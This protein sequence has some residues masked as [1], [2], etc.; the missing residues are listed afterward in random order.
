[1]ATLEAPS[2]FVSFPFL[3]PPLALAHLLPP[4]LYLLQQW[5]QILPPARSL[6]HGKLSFSR[7][8]RSF[9]TGSDS[10]SNPLSL[11]FRQDFKSATTGVAAKAMRNELN[12]MVAGVQDP[13]QKKVRSTL[14]L[15]HGSFLSRS[16]P[17]KGRSDQPPPF[18]PFPSPSTP[19]E[20]SSVYT[21]GKERGCPSSY[22][23]CADLSFVGVFC[24][25][26][27]A[28]KLR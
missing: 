7:S 16:T 5:Y 10:T 8:S 19:E 26:T 3:L 27:R 11:S 15:L 14:S 21:K 6:R 28:S 24:D 17:N 20:G 9:P 22:T 2:T 4:L 13:A 23:S 25:G 1:M 12:R 18:L